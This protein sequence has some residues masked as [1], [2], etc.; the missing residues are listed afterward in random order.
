M[1]PLLSILALS[2]AVMIGAPA[3]AQQAVG[4]AN[5]N[6]NL[7]VLPECSIEVDDLQIDSATRQGDTDLTVNCNA[8]LTLQVGLSGLPNRELSGPNGTVGYDLYQDDAHTTVWGD[9]SNSR[10]NFQVTDG[11][12]TETIFA[13][14]PEEEELPVGEY[15]DQVTATLWYTAI[16]ADAGDD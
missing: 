2:A 12:A 5:F 11:T 3:M 9:V 6:V 13:A 16:P 8:D 14:I 15:T 7:S 10:R 4:T 1:K